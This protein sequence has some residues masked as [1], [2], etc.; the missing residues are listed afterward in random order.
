MVN[1]N[2]RHRKIYEQHHGPIPRDKD[3][4]SM[5]I[6]HIDGNHSNNDIANLKL[7][8]IEEHYQIHYDQGDYGACTIMSHRMKLSPKETA[9]LSRLCQQ[10]LVSEGRHH[11]QGPDHNRYLIETGIHP[12]LDKEAARQRNLKRVA[13]GTHNLVGDTNPVHNLI[14]Q[15]T[16]HFQLD[17]PSK[18]KISDGSHH[19][20][21]NHP[22]KIQV[23]CPH[24]GKQGGAVNMRRYH[25]DNC[26]KISGRSDHH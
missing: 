5:E 6:H 13:A 23:T 18:K 15:G 8:T 12:F 21:N 16:H 11:W 9:E 26:K 24:C 17:N 7:V 19:F 25:F 3:G 22:N 14:A 1:N 10:K 4:R 20:L 2:M